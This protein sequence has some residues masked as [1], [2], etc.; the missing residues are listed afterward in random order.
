MKKKG[1]T[2]IELL[3][4]VAII[5]VLATVVLGALGDARAK[6]RDARRL[7][8]MKTIYNALVLYE[9]D[10]GFVARTSSYGSPSYFDDSSRDGFMSFLVE[11]G[12]LSEVPVD[13]ININ[14][15]LVYT[16]ETGD[17]FYRYYCGGGG[18][19]GIDGVSLIYRKESNN[20]VVIYSNSNA[21]GET[22]GS[23]HDTYLNC[24]NHS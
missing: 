15:G 7:S 3:V 6:A 22:T 12:Y 14:T 5:G 24:G 19:Y 20:S 1:F 9:L 13:P 16:W 8:D 21:I 4:V 18:T 2:L 17:Y 11:D 10:H 23:T